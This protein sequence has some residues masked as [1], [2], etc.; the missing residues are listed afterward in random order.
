[1][2]PSSA[3]VG[4]K[5][6][7]AMSSWPLPRM[8]RA[9]KPLWR[10]QANTLLSGRTAAMIS[11]GRHD[12]R[13][14][15]VTVAA[16]N[17]SVSADGISRLSLSA[18]SL[19]IRPCRSVAP[20]ISDFLVLRR[21]DVE[22]QTVV[23]AT[24]DDVALPLPADRGEVQS[25][26]DAPGRVVL[27]D[28]GVDGVQTEVSEPEGDEHRRRPRAVTARPERLFPQH[29]PD[30]GRLEGA[31]HV[32]QAAHTDRGGLVV[33]G[34]HSNDFRVPLC[35]DLQ[36]LRGQDLPAVAEVQPLEVLLPGHPAGGELDELRA[37][38]RQQLHGARTSAS[39][40]LDRPSHC[41]FSE[42]DRTPSSGRGACGPAGGGPASDTA[43]RG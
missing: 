21:Q 14:T 33:R 34:E 19:A 4:S 18:N 26:D 30:A 25:P 43:R 15:H 29:R 35:R 27:D 39:G 9:T 17:R 22:P 23:D 13:A 8:W 16:A 37:R 20:C 5:N 6:R 12:A 2:P 40:T 24:I 28:P 41:R 3:R 31:D 36:P 38:E 11:G 32:R 42:V 7:R 1:M 10:R